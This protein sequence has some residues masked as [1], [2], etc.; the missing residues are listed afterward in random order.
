MSVT[1]W[2]P[3]GVHLN[4]NF[5]DSQF[6]SKMGTRGFLLSLVIKEKICSYLTYS[7]AN[8]FREALN[9]PQLKCQIPIDDREQYLT[10]LSIVTEEIPPDTWRV[11]LS[12]T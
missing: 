9:L 6:F 12:N 10:H 4:M 8:T 11:D 5:N 3:I 2:E 1:D 7:E